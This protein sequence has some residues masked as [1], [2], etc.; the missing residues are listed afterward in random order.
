MVYELYKHHELTQVIT[1]PWSYNWM[2]QQS[3]QSFRTW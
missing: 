1:Y 2:L 3:F